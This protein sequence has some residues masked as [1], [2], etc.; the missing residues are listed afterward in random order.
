MKDYILILKEAID[1]IN[2][3]EIYYLSTDNKFKCLNERT[4]A[5]ELYYNWRIC[6][7]KYGIDDRKIDAEITKIINENFIP[8]MKSIF[9]FKDNKNH[10]CFYPD[11]VLHGGQGDYEHQEI[12]CE[13]KKYKEESR[14]ELS[15]RVLIDLKKIS[16]YMTNNTLQSSSPYILGVFVIID[17]NLRQLRRLI[18]KKDILELNDK[19]KR[20][21]CV[22]YMAEK[23]K[24]EV[25]KTTGMCTLEE[26]IENY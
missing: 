25:V 24:H 22:S 9:G 20:I 16:A 4:F 13:I 10:R 21:Y 26:L 2:P 19:S 15:K 14:T 12:S 5:Y 6:L 8:I 1:M 17:G 23:K 18:K 7:N 11:M 3:Q